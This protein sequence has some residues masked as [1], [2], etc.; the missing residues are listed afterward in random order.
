MNMR[1]K[2]G[3]LALVIRDNKG[4]EANVGCLVEVRGPVVPTRY[5]EDVTWQIAQVEQNGPWLI[6]EGDGTITAE[7]VTWDSRVVHPDSWLKPIRPGTEDEDEALWRTIHAPKHEGR[8]VGRGEAACE[9]SAP[10]GLPSQLVTNAAH[11]PL[12]RHPKDAT[13]SAQV[14]NRTA[15]LWF[16]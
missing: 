4:C 16:A 6:R 9:V 3:D 5:G 2:N 1:C 11:A 14:L 12:A 13:P 10:E 8:A 7:I 15:E